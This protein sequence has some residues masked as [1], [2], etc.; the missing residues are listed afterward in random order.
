MSNKPIEMHKLRQIIRLYRQGTG[1]KTT[2][3][4]IGVSRNTIKKYVR[5]WHELGLSYDSFS[6]TS[7]ATC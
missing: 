3:V 6:K 2:H 4:M 5:R 1:I 7:D